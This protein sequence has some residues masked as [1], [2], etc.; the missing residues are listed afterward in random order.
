M[1]SASFMP[2]LVLSTILASAQ[3]RIL[4]PSPRPP[5]HPRACSQRR[6]LHRTSSPGLRKQSYDCDVTHRALEEARDELRTE[7]LAPC[8]RGVSRTKASCPRTRV[9][10]LGL[11]RWDLRRTCFIVFLWVCLWVV[12]RGGRG[13]F[14]HLACRRASFC[15]AG[16]GFRG[17]VQ[18]F[19]CVRS[20]RR[21]RRCE[22]AARAGNPLI[23]GCILAAGVS[24]NTV[25][26]W[27]DGHVMTVC[28]A[29]RC[30]GLRAGVSLAHE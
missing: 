13:E 18:Q 28:V 27:R 17:P 16:A 29:K 22:I 15:T 26:G 6:L 23:C 11:C 7:A 30:G 3:P 8:N 4:H 9:C 25:G 24:Q 14:W 20:S 10:S 5:L 12:S 21:A 19:H 2:W 1:D